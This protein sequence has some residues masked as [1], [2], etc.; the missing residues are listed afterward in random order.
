M[1]FN[2]SCSELCII[3]FQYCIHFFGC[4]FTTSSA[5]D[6]LG[7]AADK[8]CYIFGF[9]WLFSDFFF[10]GGLQLRLPGIAWALAADKEYYIFFFSGLFASSGFL[11]NIFL[12]LLNYIRH[13]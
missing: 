10:H 11:L 13:T 12:K 9:S 6:C 5:W 2:I 3:L 8:E 7:L 4:R 1:I